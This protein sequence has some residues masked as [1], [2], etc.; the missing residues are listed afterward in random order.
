VARADVEAVV[1][2]A[3]AT[4][5]GLLGVVGAGTMGRGIAQL[6]ALAGMEVVLYDPV[7]EALD[8]A[9]AA[10]AQDLERSV[11]RGR[12]SAGEV[13]SAL[14]LVKPAGELGELARCELVIEAAPERLD[15]KAELFAQLPSDAILA[16]NT[17][18][19]S[20]TA[21]AALA[22]RPENVVGMH[23][24][25][26]PPR[27]RLVELVAGVQTSARALAVARATA[28]AMGRTPIDARDDIGFI[29]NRC[30]RP[31]Y[32][33][34]LRLVDERIADPATIDRICRLGAGFRMGPF[35]VMDLVGLDVGLDIAESFT[36]QSYGEPRWK[37]SPAQRRLVAAGRLGRKSGAGWYDYSEGAG[38]PADPAS[39]A[40]HGGAGRVLTVLGDG[41]EAD[42][43]RARAAREGFTVV[44][45][46]P[47]GGCELVLAFDPAAAHGR[48]PAGVP[49]ALSCATG[50]VA[51]FGE[52]HAAGF[53]V[54]PPAQDA[55]LI[56]LTRVPA[57]P[58]AT[59]Q[60]VEA[61]AAAL[62]LHAEWVDDSPALV[63]GR[64]VSQ[65]VNEAS[66]AV[67]AGIGDA[68]DVDLGLELGLN[69]P[70]GPFAWGE[71]IG[72]AG[73]L[74]RL[75]GLWADRHEDRYRAAPLLRR[76]VA[77]DVPVAALRPRT[78]SAS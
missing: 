49:L 42:G 12:M 70:R 57:T 30:G 52:K 8:G 51:S 46:V 4:A 20:V 44:D 40:G 50:T 36:H 10:I 13:R 43:M 11:Q 76:A 15:L 29:V 22:E 28:T 78:G 33:E 47:A 24:F 61:A 14:A 69:H 31:Y 73:V 27:M 39:P 25:N 17:S 19:L 66:F 53:H 48:V 9:V 74:A 35:E 54:L 2:A 1:T 65:L 62:G 67:G 63:L 55:T 56:E 34:A 18:S 68:Q 71:R 77:L 3:E 23:F 6:G 59:V 32:T 7:P 21:I 72:L 26:P 58:A 64:I 5:P 37:P 75:D 45:A 38:R 60:A 41:A 16:T